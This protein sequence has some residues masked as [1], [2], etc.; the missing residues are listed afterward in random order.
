MKPGS[1]ILVVED[2]PGIAEL[3]RYTLIAEGMLVEIA[4][5][6]QAAQRIVAQAMPRLVLLDWMLPDLSGIELLNRWRAN[7]ATATLPV[8]MLTAKG[9]DEDKV[10]G[11]NAGADDYVTKPF[12]PRELVA[13]IHAVLRRHVP[14]EEI[15]TQTIGAITVDDD[16][17][18]VSVHGQPVE[19]GP[20]E[21]KLLRFLIQYPERVFS[22]AQLLDKVWGNN[23]FFEER[24]VDVHVMRLRKSLGGAGSS[25]KTVRSVGYMLKADQGRATGDDVIDAK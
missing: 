25:I 24:T 17:H 13:R 7:P 16:R 8:I 14:Q 11:L 3:L 18:T 19:L 15:A 23:A 6:S 22:R 4:D 5:S 20:A 9:L 21:F 1:F 10:K 12:S 2:E